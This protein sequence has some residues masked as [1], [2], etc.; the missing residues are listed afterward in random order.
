MNNDRRFQKPLQGVV[1]GEVYDSIVDKLDKSLDDIH[2]CHY[3][4]YPTKQISQITSWIDSLD[5][6]RHTAAILIADYQQQLAREHILNYVDL[7]NRESDK[8]ID[9]YVPGYRKITD[10]EQRLFASSILSFA[11]ENNLDY[12]CLFKR[13]FDNC[14]DFYITLLKTFGYKG[15]FSIG[16]TEY[17]FDRELFNLVI[18]ELREICGIKYGFAPLLILQEFESGSMT[19]KRIVIELNT[20]KA[21]ILFE[22]IFKI[23]HR[24]VC[25][26]AFSQELNKAQFKRLLPQIIKEIIKKLTGSTFVKVVMDNEDNFTRY[27]IMDRKE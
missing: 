13:E 16:D 6:W 23:A 5:G 20:E 24:E 26:D 7:F 9:F 11:K 15:D 14:T 25:I 21:G 2:S 10:Y 18:T 1:M 27:N 4:F 19:D 3:F 8:Y 12:E 17:K 22:E